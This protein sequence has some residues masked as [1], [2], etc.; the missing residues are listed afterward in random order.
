MVGTSHKT[1]NK[2]ELTA[3][4]KGLEALNTKCQVNLIT[5]SKYGHEWHKWL[6][7]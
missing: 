7:Q 5:D 1:N 3:A 2:M 6:D 4:I